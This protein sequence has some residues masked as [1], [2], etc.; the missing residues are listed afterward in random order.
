MDLN[1]DVDV[2]PQPKPCMLQAAPGIIIAKVYEPEQNKAKLALPDGSNQRMRPIVQA[3][4]VG[5][6]RMP[7][8]KEIEAWR[9]ANEHMSAVHREDMSDEFINTI[10]ESS[11]TAAKTKTDIEVGDVFLMGPS[12]IMH[13]KDDDGEML[14]LMSFSNV[15]AKIP[16]PTR[17]TGAMVQLAG[18]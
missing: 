11:L 3:V 12:I 8:G 17:V 7:E 9:A 1:R 15:V 2:S 6:P 5:P 10:I 4:S 18:G 16:D 14:V 13:F